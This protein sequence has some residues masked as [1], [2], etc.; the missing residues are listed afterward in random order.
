MPP[1]SR[2][3]T[4]R[5]GLSS[6]ISPLSSMSQRSKASSPSLR[7]S[8][9]SLSSG[10]RCPWAGTSHCSG[11]SFSRARWWLVQPWAP[12]QA[13]WVCGMAHRSDF[14]GFRRLPPRGLPCLLLRE[15][16]MPSE[17]ISFSASAASVSGGATRCLRSRLAVRRRVFEKCSLAALS[18]VCPAKRLFDSAGNG[19]YWLSWRLLSEPI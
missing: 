5:H 18:R 19:C 7:R 4:P 1:S 12:H 11:V 17:A 8:A 6:P 15:P 10:L 3:L 16:S 14:S 13:P 9:H 2:L